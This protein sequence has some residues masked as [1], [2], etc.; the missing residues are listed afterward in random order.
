MRISL[1]NTSC[2]RIIPGGNWGKYGEYNMEIRTIEEKYNFLETLYED[3][4]DK[5]HV[6]GTNLF[7]I[8]LYTSG[9]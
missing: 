4:Q 2:G 6:I 1:N 9:N 5:L 3:L 8:K 7:Q